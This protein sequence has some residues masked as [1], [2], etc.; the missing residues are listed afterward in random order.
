MAALYLNAGKPEKAH[1]ILS[2]YLA[3]D[4]DN[5]DIRQALQEVDSKR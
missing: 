4:P 3:N 5:P 2:E 1:E